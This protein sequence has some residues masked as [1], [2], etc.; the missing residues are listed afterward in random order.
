MVEYSDLHIMV[1]YYL[2]RERVS[3]SVGDLLG[4]F[5]LDGI[6]VSSRELRK[7]CL[8]LLDHGYLS[9]K[10]SGLLR[11]RAVPQTEAVSKCEISKITRNLSAALRGESHQSKGR[12]LPTRQHESYWKV[13]SVFHLGDKAKAEYVSSPQFSKMN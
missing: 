2:K 5:A 6:D 12:P 1:C 10:R 13:P 9:A 7:I 8:R 11:F 3:L 4:M